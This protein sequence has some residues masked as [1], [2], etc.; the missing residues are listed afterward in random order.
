M[1]KKGIELDNCI[2]SQGMQRKV[3]ICC[4]ECPSSSLELWLNISILRIAV[5]KMDRDWH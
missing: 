2:I 3:Q 4:Q 5:V 1:H